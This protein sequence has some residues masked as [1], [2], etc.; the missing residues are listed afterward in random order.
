MKEKE[1][2]GKCSCNLTLRE[3]AVDDPFVE[4]HEHHVGEQQ[5]QEN[6][7]R[8]ELQDDRIAALE[9]AEKKR[10]TIKYD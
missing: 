5:K 2:E 6:N 8:Q 10:I 1:D 7:L 4:H 3:S 9:E